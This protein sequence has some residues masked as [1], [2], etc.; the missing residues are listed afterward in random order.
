MARCATSGAR[1]S[2]A[3]GR[4]VHWQEGGFGGLLINA[5]DEAFARVDLYLI[6]PARMSGRA[7]NLF[8]PLIDRD[9]LYD[10]LPESLPPAAP[11]PRRL[12]RTVGRGDPA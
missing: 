5:I 4:I 6:P 1:C 7:K 12:A 8:R 9:G 11:D 10:A 3:G 2:R